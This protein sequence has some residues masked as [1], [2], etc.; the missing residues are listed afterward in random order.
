MYLYRLF[1]RAEEKSINTKD[2]LF[3]N[4]V[5]KIQVD[6]RCNDKM[7]PVIITFPIEKISI[8]FAFLNNYAMLLTYFIGF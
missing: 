1:S 3:G 6:K 5:Q 4:F 8:A 2:G 7:N